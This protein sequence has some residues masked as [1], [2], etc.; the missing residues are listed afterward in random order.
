MRL[1]YLIYLFA[2]LVSCQN[3][4]LVKQYDS[5]NLVLN[6]GY[7]QEDDKIEGQIQPYRD[8]LKAS[9]DEVLGIS[10][11]EMVTGIPEGNLGNFVADLVL[12]IGEEYYEKLHPED[13]DIDFALLNN[14]GLRTSLPKGNITRK[15]VFE[16]MPFE[17]ELVVLTLSY[18]KTKELFDFVAIKSD[19]TLSVKKGVPLSDDV[20]LVIMDKKVISV[21]IDDKALQNKT[22]RVVTSD[23]L[24]NGGDKMD[25]FLNPIKIEPLGIK[26][27]HA[28]IEYIVEENKEGDYLKATKDNR[29]SY[30]K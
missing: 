13:D 12:E 26:L 2:F 21:S 20:E 11:V 14:G 17:N 23:Y 1:H 24:A 8:S 10:E 3:Q 30:G 16:L 22:Y 29:I 4:F 25:F 19:T 27:R 28:I 5:Q 18:E 9:M 6:D 15:K 7:K